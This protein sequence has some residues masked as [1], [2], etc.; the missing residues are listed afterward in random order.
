MR[1]RKSQERAGTQ[2][3]RAG[4]AVVASAAAVVAA[5]GSPALA[6]T[7]NVTFTPTQIPSTAGTTLTVA[8]TGAFTTANSEVYSGRFVPST[9]T[10]TGAIPAV[11]ASAIDAGTVTRLDDD[12]ATV[13]TPA[14]PPALYKLCIWDNFA[15]TSGSPAAT[16]TSILSTAVYGSLSTNHGAAGDKITLNSNAGFTA[17]SY[18]TQLVSGG[19]V[20]PTTYTAVS[21]SAVVA[22]TAKTSTSVL[23]VTIPAGLTAGTAYLVCS[24]SGT[25]ATTSP[26][27]ARGSTSFTTFDKTLP[28]VGISPTGGSSGATTTVTLSA[29]GT[30]GVFTGSSPTALVTRGACPGTYPASLSGEPYAASVTKISNLKVAATMPNTVV[31]NSG[32]VTTAWNVCTYASSTQGAAMLTTP[33]PFSVAPVLDVSAAKFAVGSG[34]AETSGSGP[35]Q[36][37]QS[38]TIS[39]V[40]GI[41]T[42]TGAVLSASLGGSPINNIKALSATEFTGTTTARAAGAVNLSVTTAAGTRSTTG[43]PYTYTY[44]ITVTPNSAPNTSNPIL[45]ITGA[46]FGTLEFA[47]VAAS[48]PIPNKSYVLLT[49]NAWYTQ[50]FTSLGSPYADV[51]KPPTSYCN[52]ILPISDNEIIC[53]LALT[54]SISAVATNAPTSLAGTAVPPGTYTITV[55]NDADDLDSADHD[56]SIVTSGSTFTVSGY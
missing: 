39:N 4:V 37:G 32:D 56:F 5:T 19:T 21:N 46:G 17:T 30:T 36:G 55:V 29:S 48:T 13:V 52:T 20:C 40:Q 7:V 43:T 22:T 16:S 10:C 6:T 44:G 23:T 18:A 24:Y 27:I 1:K 51:A 50:T 47:D 33:V 53:T 25:T 11:G 54:T 38:I 31:V 12:S 35:A 41:P 26:L 42:A 28:T 8:G 34:A 3:L 49:N 45:D 9:T 14:L 2:I 15:S